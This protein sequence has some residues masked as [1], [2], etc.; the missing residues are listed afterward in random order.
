LTQG[1]SDNMGLWDARSLCQAGSS[2]QQRRGC[3]FH[4]QRQVH[5]V[6]GWSG[7]CQVRAVSTS[8]E[9]NP[10]E[11]ISARLSLALG[12]LSNRRE[13]DVDFQWTLIFCKARGQRSGACASWR[14]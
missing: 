11:R 1:G 12:L 3:G 13:K 9:I 10:Y 7:W 14:L 5:L 6:A 8:C 2:P 4:V